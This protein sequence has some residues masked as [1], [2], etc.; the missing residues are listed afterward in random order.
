MNEW[1]SIWMKKRTNEW[2]NKQTN[3]QTNKI[4]NK[5]TNKNNLRQKARQITK[6]LTFWVTIFSKCWH[7][8]AKFSF[9]FLQSWKKIE[10]GVMVQV[11]KHELFSFGLSGLTRPHCP[12]LKESHFHRHNHFSYRYFLYFPTFILNDIG[13]FS[14][15]NHEH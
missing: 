12:S 7:N 14:N 13:F 10:V 5:Q 9:F 2:A 1:I 4:T 6:F 15:L 11:K 3:K 8:F